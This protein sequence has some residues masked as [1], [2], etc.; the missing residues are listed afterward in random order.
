MRLALL[1]KINKINKL[2]LSIATIRI[3]FSGCENIREKSAEELLQNEKME[4]DVYT[5]IFKDRLHL[6]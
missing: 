4:A 5:A 3:L 2:L 1:K 6:N